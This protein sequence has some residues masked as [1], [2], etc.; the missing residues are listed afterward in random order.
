MDRPE[1]VSR[2]FKLK[3]AKILQDIRSGSWEACSVRFTATDAA[4]TAATATAAAT[5]AA[6]T[7]ARAVG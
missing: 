2:V 6:T 5:A 4:A 1:L 3:R 7:A